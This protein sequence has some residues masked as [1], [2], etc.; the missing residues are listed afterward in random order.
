MSVIFKNDGSI[1]IA[2]GKAIDSCRFCKIAS[3]GP[4]PRDH[5]KLAEHLAAKQAS[6]KAIA[7]TDA[8][9]LGIITLNK[10]VKVST[11]V[12]VAKPDKPKVKKEP[13][14]YVVTPANA[15]TKVFSNKESADKLTKEHHA[16]L[17]KITVKKE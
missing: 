14:V 2:G 7:L 5:S 8:Q 16:K 1:E 10:I 12:Q 13:V 3:F 15:P 6:P 17:E 4:I 9:A 11:V